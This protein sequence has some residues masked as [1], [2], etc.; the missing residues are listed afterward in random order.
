MNS[1]IDNDSA[2]LHGPSDAGLS[3]R[4]DGFVHF[5][6]HPLTLPP[7]ERAVLHLMVRGWPHAISKNQFAQEIWTGQAMSDESLARCVTRLRR[8]VPPELG[9]SI[10]PV[11][12][13][14]YRLVLEPTDAVAAAP[15]VTSHARLLHDA[16]APV[17]LVETLTHARQLIQQRTPVALLRAEVLLRNLTDA[18]PQYMA[19]QVA[20]AECLAYG[21]SSGIREDRGLIDAGLSRLDMVE[22]AAPMTPGLQAEKAHLLD[23]AW[24]FDAAATAHALA[25]KGATGD[26]ATQL[27]LG[28]HLL[29]TGRAQDAVHSLRTARQL[30]PFSVNVS[31]LLARALAFTGDTAGGLDEARRCHEAAPENLQ[32]Y[33]HFL[34]CQAYSQPAPELAT[35]ARAILVG[36]ASWAYAASSLAYTLA[37]CGAPNDA[38]QLIR[39][40]RSENANARAS[41]IGT[42]LVLGQVDE[43][44]QRAQAAARTGCGPLPFLLH[45]PENT[46]LRAHA[47]FMSLTAM[48]PR[49]GSRRVV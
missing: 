9:L 4:D 33:V 8:L 25:S 14:G 18:A 7:K 28:L 19:A 27:Y 22:Q 16:M 21:I 2:R 41:Y 29:Y 6:G 15:P 10:Q 38:R 34:G 47:D 23:C 30:N 5:R 20:Y 3:I 36:P 32:A 12:R 40:E 45:A 24:Q 42:L 11:Y 39:S 46:G 43:A 13:H 37:R 48:I 44:M 26:A 31:V 17:H 49:C 35:E 1:T